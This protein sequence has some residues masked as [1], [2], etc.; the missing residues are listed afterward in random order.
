MTDSEFQKFQNLVLNLK[1][2]I[3][4]EINGLADRLDK[5]M[6]ELTKE[7]ALHN[8]RGEHIESELENLV[9]SHEKVKDD[10]TANS[11]RIKVMWGLMATLVGLVVWVI[12]T[13][14]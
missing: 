2:D 10:T 5:D 14:N 1:I 12:K 4:R 8:Q 3:G 9:K 13:I 7:L 6:A 11:T